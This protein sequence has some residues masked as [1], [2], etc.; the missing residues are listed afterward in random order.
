MLGIF[1]SGVGGLSVL[2]KEPP[3]LPHY[4][5]SDLGGCFR[6]LEF[7]INTLLGQ[8]TPAQ[9]DVCTLRVRPGFEDNVVWDGNLPRNRPVTGERLYLVLSGDFDYQKIVQEVPTRGRLGGPRTLQQA[10]TNSWPGLRMVAEQAPAGLLGRSRGPNTAFFRIP[11]TEYP[12]SKTGVM[13]N[14][15]SWE[16]WNEIAQE[17]KVS[18]YL[19]E[20]L[21]RRPLPQLDLVYVRDGRAA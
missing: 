17:G 19:P 14:D 4:D 3:T 9:I 20:D 5:H 12:K 13:E 8:A 1:D 7:E 18:V 15:R 11:T 16:L 21:L 6:A 10:M 2:A